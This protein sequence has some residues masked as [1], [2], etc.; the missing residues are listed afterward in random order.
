MITADQLPA[1]GSHHDFRDP[2]IWMEG[3][4][5]YVVI[6]NRCADGSGTILLCKSK[7]A[8]HWDFVSIVASCHNQYGK[9]WECPDFFELDDRHVLFT[10]PQEMSAIGLE[11]HPGNA[12]V[13]LIGS[14]DRLTNHLNRETVQAIDYGLDFYAP[15]TLRTFDGRR[16]MIAWMQNWETSSCMLRDLG[17]MGQMT[18][19]R[20]LSVKNGR[21][22]QAPV[23]K[24]ES[25]RG[26]REFPVNADKGVL[27]FRIIMDRYSLELFV[28]DGKQAA[29][30]I[31]YTPVEAGAIS[32]ASDDIVFADIEKYELR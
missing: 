22:Y 23:R 28:N 27:K 1:G 17:F 18:L 11:F 5:F 13:C 20:E 15:Q 7:D 21:L 8:I 32:F 25:C 12:N 29:S 9:M 19:P 14:F 24:L 4:T 3:D 31:L 26:V 10:S 16:I 30:F 2:K 6:G